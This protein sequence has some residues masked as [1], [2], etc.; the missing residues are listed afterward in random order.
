[1]TIVFKGRVV[2]FNEPCRADAEFFHQMQ[3]ARA[4]WEAEGRPRSGY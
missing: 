2:L 3:A 4:K 1:V